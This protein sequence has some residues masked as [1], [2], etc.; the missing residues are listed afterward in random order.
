MRFAGLTL[1]LVTLNFVLSP[2]TLA[3]IETRT[4]TLRFSSTESLGG[5]RYEVNLFSGYTSNQQIL[6]KNISNQRVRFE[7][8]NGS[9][10]E[11]PS[12]ERF[13]VACAPEEIA[14]YLQLAAR[15]SFESFPEPVLCGDLLQV[16]DAH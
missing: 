6:I 7:G 3:A 2:Y 10:A 16:K 15:D 4:E 8:T 13:A 5:V 12:G 11:V 9:L 14:G 1:W